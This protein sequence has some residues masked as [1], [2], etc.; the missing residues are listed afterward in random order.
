[1]SAMNPRKESYAPRDTQSVW[2]K[3]RSY[4]IAGLLVIAPVFITIWIVV[5]LFLF[6]DGFLGKPI[7]HALGSWIGIEYFQQHT[8]PGAGFIALV[9]IVL[10]A[11][12]F[13]KQYLGVRTVSIMNRIL[14][15][16]PLV[17]KVY[18]AVVQISEALLGGQRE[19]FKYA[20]LIEYPKEDVYS[21]GFVTQDT[22]GAVQDAINGDVISVFIP[23]TPNPTSGYLLFVPKKDVTYLDLSVEEALKLIISAGAV[24][25]KRGGAY[26][27]AKSLGISMSPM[28]PKSGSDKK[29]AL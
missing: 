25:P 11:G 10:A 21:I 14:E 13:A 3:I 16:V 9:L 1:M 28:Q 23:T 5:N 24:I 26:T 4:F 7:Q 22:K 29:N 27:D 2:K 17:N 8:L 19:V 20:V 12:W 18:T 15:K 6:A